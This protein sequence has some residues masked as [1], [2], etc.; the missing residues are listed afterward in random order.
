ML[1]YDFRSCHCEEGVFGLA[2][3]DNKRET[4]VIKNS[5]M[6]SYLSLVRSKMFIPFL[7][8]VTFMVLFSFQEVFAQMP[9]EPPPPEE[10]HEAVVTQIVEEG[11]T[12]V[13]Q[14]VEQPFQKVEAQIL[15]GEMKREKSYCSGGWH[16]TDQ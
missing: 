11:Q 3:N 10:R 13:A 1:I 7:L 4:C 14:G 16:N 5:L 8:G 9:P 6:K 2:R 12:E 15:E